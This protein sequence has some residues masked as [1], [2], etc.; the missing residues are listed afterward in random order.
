VPLLGEP[1]T[2]W[3]VAG[4]ALVSAGAWLSS[5]VPAAAPAA[6]R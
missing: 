6:P 5:R 4:L 3:L 1:L 2:L